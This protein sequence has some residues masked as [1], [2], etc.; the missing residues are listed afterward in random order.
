MASTAMGNLILGQ[1]RE[2]FSKEEYVS[3]EVHMSLRERKLESWKKAEE[4]GVFASAQYPALGYTRCVNGRAVASPGGAA[5]TFRCQN[6]D[7]YHFLS[8]DTL[9]DTRGEGSSSW[10]WTNTD[11]R[12]FVSQAILH[13]RYVSSSSRPL[14]RMLAQSIASTDIRHCR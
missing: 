13:V 14:G 2:S 9:G 4:A 8:H 12:E 7:L 3:G 6:M 5:N 11:G 10:G 1:G